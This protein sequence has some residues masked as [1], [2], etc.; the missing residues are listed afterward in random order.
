M[1]RMS[2]SKRTAARRVQ[3][4]ADDARRLVEVREEGPEVDLGDEPAGEEGQLDEEEREPAP[5]R[6][7]PRDL[8]LRLRKGAGE[9]QP[10]RPA[11][12]RVRRVP[13]GGEDEPGAAERTA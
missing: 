13:E 6:E 2:P 11:E 7:V 1:R 4:A 5:E 9:A 10:R 8:G 3:E 12:E